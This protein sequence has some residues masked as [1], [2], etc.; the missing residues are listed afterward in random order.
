MTSAEAPSLVCLCVCESPGARAS[1]FTLSPF[2]K[3]SKNR[4]KKG[5]QK[6]CFWIKNRPLD[7]QG[8]KKSA[9]PARKYPVS[10]IDGPRAASRAVKDLKET[11]KQG[12]KERVIGSDT[13]LGRWPGEFCCSTSFT[14]WVLW[15]DHFPSSSLIII[16]RRLE[17]S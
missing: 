12:H 11:R 14:V 2:L 9:R 16:H 17:S 13:P 5:A 6:S 1:C 15:W 8:P 4:Y 7:A 10:G 3:K